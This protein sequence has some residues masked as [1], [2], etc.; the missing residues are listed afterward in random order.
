MIR[1]RSVMIFAIFVSRSN[2]SILS[3]FSSS[4]LIL[5]LNVARTTQNPKTNETIEMI[6]CGCIIRVWMSILFWL[7]YKV[8]M[9]VLISKLLAQLQFILHNHLQRPSFINLIINNIS[10]TEQVPFCYYYMKYYILLFVIAYNLK[11]K[12]M[13]YIIK[14]N[15]C[16][17]PLFMFLYYVI[18]PL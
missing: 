15:P 6:V 2:L 16:C 14:Q 3:T 17:C 8:N 1:S 13:E 18:N 9:F 4:A 10:F 7:L 12:H 5:L 11:P